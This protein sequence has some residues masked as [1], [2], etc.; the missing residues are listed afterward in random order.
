[1]ANNEYYLPGENPPASNRGGST[2]PL[3]AVDWDT[4]SRLPEWKRNLVAALDATPAVAGMGGDIGAGILGLPLES[5]NAV[6]PGLGLLT[7][8]G[9]TATGGAL[10]GAAGQ[11]L[12]EGGYRMLGLGDAPGTVPKAF[13]EQG[14]MGALGQ[15]MAPVI[16]AGART[17]YEGLIRPSLKTLRQAPEVARQAWEAG[18]VIPKRGQQS[19]LRDQVTTLRNS[20]DQ[21]VQQAG[22]PVTTR[23][24]PQVRVNYGQP[25][26]FQPFTNGTVAVPPSVS[27]L[28][29]HARRQQG[30]TAALGQV[31]KR[32]GMDSGELLQYVQKPNLDTGDLA[33]LFNRYGIKADELNVLRG[34]D[35]GPAPAAQTVQVLTPQPT[36]PARPTTVSVTPGKNVTKTPTV[37]W[38]EIMD[39]RDA[40][41]AKYKNSDTPEA[42]D[43][44]NEYFDSIQKKWNPANDPNRE[45]TYEQVQD[46]KRGAQTTAES[47][48]AKDKAPGYSKPKPYYEAAQ[49]AAA[50]ARRSLGSGASPRVPGLNEANARTSRMANIVTAVEETANRTGNPI[51][52]PLTPENLIGALTG[53]GSGLGALQHFGDNPIAATATG[54]GTAIAS[55]MLADSN[56]PAISS[57]LLYL[58]KDPAARTAVTQVPR[59]ADWLLGYPFNTSSAAAGY[60][61]FP[62]DF[63]VPANPGRPGEFYLPGEL[64]P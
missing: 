17:T 34:M 5:L 1:M 35:P 27:D 10:T 45:L 55:K 59:V 9:F 26:Q 62:T 37:P 3:P 23:V 24:P 48:Y 54:A 52:A 63:G 21:M 49:R 41:L 22:A 32:V 11:A 40:L 51:H 31:A 8:A 57:A 28:A 15:A 13:N 61:S 2:A 25:A 33:T 43:A 14:T 44:I 16:Q 12:R 58:G 4:W 64:N 47:Q 7:H 53:L 60:G 36:I 30:F 42:E 29:A 6:V 39:E 46:F 50:A 20:A 19:A 18:A 38:R 56:R